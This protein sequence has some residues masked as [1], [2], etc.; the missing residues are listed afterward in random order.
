[1]ETAS[2][3]DR[4]HDQDLRTWSSASGACESICLRLDFR[5]ARCGGSGQWIAAALRCNNW[6]SDQAFMDLWLWQ[7]AS[8]TFDHYGKSFR[9]N[10]KKKNKTKKKRMNVHPAQRC[11][12]G[13]ISLTVIAESL[14][15]QCWQESMK[16]Q[17]KKKSENGLWLWRDS[18]A[19]DKTPNTLVPNQ[20]YQPDQ[21]AHA[22]ATSTEWMLN[23]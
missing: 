6:C 3:F 2:P 10:V 8:G 16:T 21:A 19:P 11:F 5:Q 17:K 13:G 1:M 15:V 22:G 14:S 20:Y 9:R 4:L 18:Q 23:M 7:S 12:E